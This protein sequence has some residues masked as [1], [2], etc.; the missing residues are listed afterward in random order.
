MSPKDKRK[1]KTNAS[2]SSGNQNQNLGARESLLGRQ[3]F[4]CNIPHTVGWQDIKDLMRDAGQ[5]VRVNIMAGQPSNPRNYK[6]QGGKPNGKK[7]SIED[8]HAVILFANSKDA[9]K[10]IEIFNG[11]EWKGHRLEVIED[12]SL[13]QVLKPHEVDQIGAGTPKSS[14]NGPE[15]GFDGSKFAGKLLENFAD[16]ATAATLTLDKNTPDPNPTKRQVSIANI[17]YIIGWQDLKD[18]F[19]EAGKVVRADI[20]N[21]PKTGKS[22]GQG[23]VVFAHS[24]QAELAVKMFNEFEWYGRKLDVG[25]TSSGNSGKGD[26]KNSGQTLDSH[27]GA[28]KQSHQ[29]TSKAISKN[30]AY[31]SKPSKNI[32]TEEFKVD[33]SYSALAQSPNTARSWAEKVRLGLNGSHSNSESKIDD[34]QNNPGFVPKTSNASSKISFGSSA[35]ISQ[36]GSYSGGSQGSLSSLLKNAASGSMSHVSQTSNAANSQICSRDSVLDDPSHSQKMGLSGDRIGTGG[37]AVASQAGFAENTDLP[38]ELNPSGISKAVPIQTPIGF[39]R[40]LQPAV[41]EIIGI[42]KSIGRNSFQGA[43]VGLSAGDFSAGYYPGST[44]IHI[45]KNPPNSY[46]SMAGSNSSSLSQQFSLNQNGTNGF[47]S[48]YGTSP[49]SSSA[50]AAN[51]QIMHSSSFGSSNGSFSHGSST[52]LPN[53]D[54]SLNKLQMASSPSASKFYNHPASQ[55]PIHQSSQPIDRHSLPP[56][57]YSAPATQKPVSNNQQQPSRVAPWDWDS[58]D[59]QKWSLNNPLNKLERK[60]PG[61]G[62][63]G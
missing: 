48:N 50:G 37:M 1:S 36:Y 14:L 13:T 32:Q 24:A 33:V 45:P 6:A 16:S 47:S 62:R 59:S 27:K 51:A 31:E 10:A 61:Y 34:I 35:G 5:V 38:L 49:K 22:K 25:F 8:I 53:I 56:L 18:L 2:A 57:Q 20:K 41:P 3:L 28:E 30:T 54:A 9:H 42:P 23:S 46:V 29:P 39:E 12:R 4:L 52:F 58:S 44:N 63:P 21:D 17:P 40:K 43:Q 26:R 19:R 55:F 60:A 7:Q 15:A 11:F